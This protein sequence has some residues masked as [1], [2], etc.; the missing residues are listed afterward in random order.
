M[1]QHALFL[2]QKPLIF[3]GV[4][5]SFFIRLSTGEGKSIFSRP[6]TALAR[7]SL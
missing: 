7:L 1:H 3:W 5:H 4:A 2:I 6:F